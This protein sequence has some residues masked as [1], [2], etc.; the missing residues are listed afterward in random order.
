MITLVCQEELTPCVWVLVGHGGVGG[1]GQRRIEGKG[2][3]FHGF[4]HQTII[5][6]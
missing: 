1:K 5:C 3:D 4:D 2:I 6:S